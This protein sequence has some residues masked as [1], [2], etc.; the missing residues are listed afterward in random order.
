MHKKRTRDRLI[1]AGAIIHWP[2]IL[3]AEELALVFHISEEQAESLLAS[4]EFGPT[5]Y[6]ASR[7]G[8]LR[9][10][11]HATLLKASG[12]EPDGAPRCPGTKEVRS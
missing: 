12:L 10:I 1:T 11:L 6:V 5:C 9:E 8:V 3:F 7:R 4:E 2:R